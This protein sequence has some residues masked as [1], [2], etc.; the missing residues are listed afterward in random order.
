[1]GLNWLGTVCPEGSVNWEPIVG[2]QMS[3]DHMRLGPNVSQTNGIADT[4][5]IQRSK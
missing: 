2:H 3:G 4:E 5:I 1:M